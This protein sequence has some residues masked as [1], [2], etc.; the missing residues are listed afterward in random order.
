M[1]EREPI[2]DVLLRDS[3]HRL[4]H[5]PL[6]DIVDHAS[7]NE[8]ER[9][10]Q[11]ASIPGIL[12][13]EAVNG[14][15][16]DVVVVGAGPA[17]GLAAS[18]LA[19]ANLNV[20]LVEAKPFPRHKV[21][22]GC[23]NR[24]AL[25][26]LDQLDVSDALR[27]AG[28][29]CLNALHLRCGKRRV[30]WDMPEMLATSRNLLDKTLVQQAISDGAA[31]LP[32][33]NARIIAVEKTFPELSPL[34]E[35]TLHHTHGVNAT[36]FARVVI[37]ADGI[38][39]SSLKDTDASQLQ[40]QIKR[41]SRIGLGA[42][43]EDRS[44]FY[45]QELLTMSVGRAGY[46]GLTRIEN[47]LLN[48]AAAIDP[49]EIRKGISPFDVIKGILEE[50]HLPVPEQSVNVHWTGTPP[51]TRSTPAPSDHR[52]FLIGDA[53]G[54]I[55]PFTGEGMAWALAS[56][57][58]VVPFAVSACSAWNGQL[59]REWKRML[60]RKVG[61]RQWICRWLAKLLR[62]PTL[63]GSTLDACRYLPFLP[64]LAM[65]YM[66]RTKLDGD[67]SIDRALKSA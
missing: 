23:L 64:R 44:S 21:C 56:A 55:E 34:R 33:T 15:T 20:L 47:G 58:A 63:A 2:D 17:G 5:A 28:A 62:H 42:I 29:V 67:P 54:Y 57:H 6:R 60:R 45:P 24:R 52:L 48:V 11:V 39:H 26:Y 19:R 65:S 53:T 61:R 8:S 9:H 12:S 38:G 40:S 41:N 50:C 59:S 35:I 66:N 49:Q 22:G 10:D 13:P 43:I 51:L 37:C 32:S 18:L 1:T 3:V 46:V 30:T 36:V 31:F 25:H 16:Y 27:N 7:N 4:E 14:E